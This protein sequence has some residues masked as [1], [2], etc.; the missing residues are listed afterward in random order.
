MNRSTPEATAK[1]QNSLLFLYKIFY[2]LNQRTVKLKSIGGLYSLLAGK[3]R[4]IWLP[5]ILSV[6]ATYLSFSRHWLPLIFIASNNWELLIQKWEKGELSNGGGVNPLDAGYANMAAQAAMA[7][8]P[9][10][11]VPHLQRP[12]QRLWELLWEVMQTGW[13]TSTGCIWPPGCMLDSPELNKWTHMKSFDPPFPEIVQ[14]HM[15]A[16]Q[17]K[18]EMYICSF[19]WVAQWKKKASFHCRRCNCFLQVWMDLTWTDTSTEALWEPIDK[20]QPF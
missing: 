1:V 6:A 17:S 2:Q 3:E 16:D 8:N 20:S 11:W 12:T 9:V 7:R 5:G 18:D 19:S 15:Q 4:V 13:P 14:H 10:A